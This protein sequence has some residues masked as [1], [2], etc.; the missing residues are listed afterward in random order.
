MIALNQYALLRGAPKA[1]LLAFIARV[2]EVLE[3]R[4]LESLAMCAGASYESQLKFTPEYYRL[5]RIRKEEKRRA[6][7]KAL[8]RPGF[9]LIAWVYYDTMIGPCLQAYY[10]P[11]AGPRRVSMIHGNIE[12]AAS[13]KLVEG[14]PG[15]EAFKPHILENIEHA[16]GAWDYGTGY[17]TPALHLL[18]KG[19]DRRPAYL[20]RIAEEAH[21]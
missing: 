13:L 10:L 15:R 21:S 4:W 9:I 8:E 3:G 19:P 20:R 11:E 6:L 17:G 1:E 5:E 2:L 14:K 12:E 7:E 16:T 18:D